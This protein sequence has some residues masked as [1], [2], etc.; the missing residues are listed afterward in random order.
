LGMSRSGLF[1]SEE[2]Y[3]LAEVASGFNRKTT[4]SPLHGAL[5]ASAVLNGGKLMSPSLID[6]VTNGKG[7]TVYRGQTSQI[8]QAISPNTA[9]VLSDLMQATI[10]SGTS[11]RAFSGYRYD[12][13]L[14][15]LIIGGKTGSISNVTQ[16]SKYDWFVGFAKEKGRAESIA[17]S[18][19][20]VHG[21]TLSRKAGSYAR[22]AIK[23]YYEEY[24][25]GKNSNRRS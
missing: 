11:R 13:V 6:R 16:T 20:V 22:M 5:I 9:S 21:E 15:K 17:I 7:E 18:V 10:R 24:F 12:R 14:S 19:L 1:V 25:N 8:S 23:A 2:P 4:L 3:H